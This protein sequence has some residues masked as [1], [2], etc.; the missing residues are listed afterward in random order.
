M[1][2][3]WGAL[4]LGDAGGQRGRSPLV[5]KLHVPSRVSSSLAS[6]T[7][8]VFSHVSFRKPLG[9]WAAPDSPAFPPACLVAL[10]PAPL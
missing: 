1:G 2:K 4:R 6:V 3:G 8:D 10:S 9:A 7:T 5:P